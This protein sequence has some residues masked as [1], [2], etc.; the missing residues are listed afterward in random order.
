MRHDLTIEGI[1]FR[2][3]P[4]DDADAPL[5]R[6]LRCD[7]ERN[8]FLHPTSDDLNDQLTW[9]ARYYKR[10]NDY[11]FVVEQLQDGLT[12]G[13]ISLYDI[14]D[15]GN[16][17]EWGRWILRSNSLAAV[18]S[19]WLIYRCAFEI[20][21]LQEVYSR[22]VAQNKSVV[23]FHD[24]C[25]IVNRCVLPGHFELDGRRMDAVEHR[26]GKTDW[27]QLEVRLKRLVMLTGQRIQRA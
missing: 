17:G 6:D 19:A 16:R 4:I 21:R 20:L 23:S 3:R 9:L 25:G 15:A 24:S 7:P 18:E 13:F 14:D 8:R 26:V 1:A 22:T 12:E 11:Y 5:V 27:A 10:P 2:L